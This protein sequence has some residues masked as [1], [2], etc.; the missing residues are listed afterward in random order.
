MDPALGQAIADA[1]VKGNTTADVTA[2]DDVAA[3]QQTV[4][5]LLQSCDVFHINCIC[6]VVA[7][8]KSI[9]NF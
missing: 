8:A 2:V 9:C 7:L 4:L 3:L 6:C 1:F 5:K